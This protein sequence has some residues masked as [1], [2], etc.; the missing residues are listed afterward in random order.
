MTEGTYSET[1]ESKQ[2]NKAEIENE[3]YEK[4]KL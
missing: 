3:W 4:Q 2:L 1:L